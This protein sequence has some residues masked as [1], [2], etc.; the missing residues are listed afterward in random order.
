MRVYSRVLLVMTLQGK[1]TTCGC[2]IKEAHPLGHLSHF[3]IPT[4]LKILKCCFMYFDDLCG[5]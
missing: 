1:W 4:K 5:D 2:T 3:F